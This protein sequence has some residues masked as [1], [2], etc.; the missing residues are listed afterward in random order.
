MQDTAILDSDVVS[1][2][3]DVMGQDFQVLVDSFQRDGEQRLT[4]LR[5]AL[6]E[7]D[8]ETLRCQAHSF[9]GSSGNLGAARVCQLCLQLESL[10]TEGELDQ[11]PTFLDSLERAFQQACEALQT[12]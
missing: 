6:A 4:A 1:E 2:L 5:A 8:T 7:Q 3:Q 10:A 11:V 9:K 12:L